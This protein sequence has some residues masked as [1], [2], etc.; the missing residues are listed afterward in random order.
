MNNDKYI[1][2]IDNQKNKKQFYYF[3]TEVLDKYNI[4]YLEVNTLN[5]FYNL[6]DK[7]N[8][9]KGVILSGSNKRLSKNISYNTFLLNKL[10]IALNVPVLGIC[11]G[12]QFLNFF[13]KGT[14]SQLPEFCNQKILININQKYKNH[15]LLKGI[16]EK[17]FAEC[18]NN[19]FVSQKGENMKIIA[20]H[21]DINQITID[22]KRKRYG[23][24]FHPELKKSTYPLLFNFIYD[25]CKY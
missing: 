5:Q 12:M 16:K 11:Y 21:N 20:T 13:D 1:L 2:I 4:N 9:I 8:N 18:K 10:A 17:F 6:K 15:K 3:L 19:D 14:I 24:Q 7:L 25:I 23:I 22:D